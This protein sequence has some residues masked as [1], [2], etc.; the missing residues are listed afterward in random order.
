MDVELC[1]INLCQPELSLDAQ[2]MNARIGRLEQQLKN[3]MC[4]NRSC[5]APTPCKNIDPDHSD[6]LA[7]LRKVRAVPGVKKVFIRSGIRYD[8]MLCEKNSE[9]FSD[10]VKHHISGQ[11]KVAPEHCS[12]QVLD[13]MGKPHFDV[14]EKFCDKYQRLNQRYGLEQYMG[15]WYNVLITLSQVGIIYLILYAMYR[16]KIFLK[17]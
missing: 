2:S 3:G 9:F 6:Y 15:D 5:L 1:L 13:Y 11:L 16:K 17:A 14:Y 8:Y 4:K 12:S 7:L 10:L